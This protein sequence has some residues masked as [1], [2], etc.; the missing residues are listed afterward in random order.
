M[1]KVIFVWI[2]IPIA[3]TV[4]MMMPTFIAMSPLLGW[5]LL[6]RILI[7]TFFFI[8]FVYTLT[9]PGVLLSLIA[10]IPAIRKRTQ[11]N[12][13]ERLVTILMIMALSAMIIILTLARIKTELY[14][15]YSSTSMVGSDIESWEGYEENRSAIVHETWI[16]FLIPP[17]LRW[18]CYTN[19]KVVCSFVNQISATEGLMR[20]DSYLWNLLFA[21][22]LSLPGGMFARHFTRK[23]H[24][25]DIV[26][27]VS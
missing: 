25:Q 4:I 5:I 12:R 27:E 23:D 26:A 17:F 20:L 24:P 2:A 1:K 14:Y 15:E 10:L 18:Q 13:V 9:F 3:L 7:E 6:E 8:I 16:R 21:L 11:N 22:A 19:N